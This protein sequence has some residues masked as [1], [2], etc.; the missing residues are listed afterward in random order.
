MERKHIIFKKINNLRER[1]EIAEQEGQFPDCLI[2][3]SIRRTLTE[4]ENNVAKHESPYNV[5]NKRKSWVVLEALKYLSPGESIY[6]DVAPYAIYR[7][8]KDNKVNLKVDTVHIYE[9]L[10][11]AREETKQKIFKVT[12]REI[13]QQNRHVKL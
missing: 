4:I 13:P 11:Y 7:W 2:L 1:I 3:R 12:V 5:V 9:R 10:R 6:T 8:G